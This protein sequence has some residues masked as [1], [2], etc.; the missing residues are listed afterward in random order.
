MLFTFVHS[1]YLNFSSFLFASQ[2]FLWDY[3]PFP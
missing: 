2:N 3:S 1:F